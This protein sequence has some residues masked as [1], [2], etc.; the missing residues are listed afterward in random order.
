MTVLSVPEAFG[1]YSQ[2]VRSRLAAIDALA[3]E[4]AYDAAIDVLTQ[5]VATDGVVHAFGTGHSEG[6]AMELAGRAGGLVPTNKVAL[7]DVA[8]IGDR[9]LADLDADPPL[10]RDPDVAD[11]LWATVPRRPSDVFVIASNSGVNGSVVGLAL[12]AREAGH[13]VIAV[14]SLVHTAAVA[15]TH[16]S[17][18]RLAEIA[19]ITLD[20]H[21]PY[22]DATLEAGLGAAVGAV[23]SIT[24]AYLAQIL[25]IGTTARLQ[26]R[27]IHPPVYLSANIPGGHQRNQALESHYAGRIRRS[28]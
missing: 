2:Q 16:R 8:L 22:G 15:P 23:S 24:A 9:A 20:N 21:A 17:G 1:D 27:G 25:T 7:R 12:H 11:D 5:C 4:G 28:A 10:E 14:T 19:D 13:Q 3:R 26:Q 18:L 6:F